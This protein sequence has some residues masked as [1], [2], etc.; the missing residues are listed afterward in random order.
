M[1]LCPT[2]PVAPMIP[3]LSLFFIFFLRGRGP[4]PFLPCHFSLYNRGLYHIVTVLSITPPILLYT[5]I[6]KATPASAA[7]LRQ[8]T[9]DSRRYSKKAMPDGT[10]GIR[11]EEAVTVGGCECFEDAPWL[12]AVITSLPC[13]TAENRGYHRKFSAVTDPSEFFG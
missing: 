4:C 8:R 5:E 12:A 3:A 6:K 2:I 9:A 13:D 10:V 7:F 1:S 11:D